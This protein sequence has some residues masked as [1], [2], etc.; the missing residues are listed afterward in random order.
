[1]PVKIW[2]K[3]FKELESLPNEEKSASFWNYF[4]GYKNAMEDLSKQNL[5]FKGMANVLALVKNQ[6]TPPSIESLK[7][8]D[9]QKRKHLLRRR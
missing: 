2:L 4:K 5:S 9:A 8:T 3:L 1:M 7:D 6:F